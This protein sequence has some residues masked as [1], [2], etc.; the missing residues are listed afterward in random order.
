[1]SSRSPSILMLSEPTPPR[2]GGGAGKYAWQLARQLQ[3]LGNTITLVTIDP[4]ADGIEERDGVQLLRV[5]CRDYGWSRQT[6]AE[7]MRRL[8]PLLR[9]QHAQRRFGLVHDVGGFLYFEVFRQFILETRIPGITHL[10]LL[11]GPYLAEAQI[12]RWGVEYFHSLQELQCG[13]SE[14]V[15]TTSRAESALYRGLFRPPR[16]DDLMIPNG[17]E[18]QELDE[19]RCK[20]WRK[21]LRRDS[22]LLLFVGGRVTDHVKGVQ[23]AIELCRALNARG[24]PARLVATDLRPTRWNQDHEELTYLGRLEDRDLAAVLSCVDVVLCPSHYEAFGLLAVEALSLGVPVV[25]SETGGHLDVVHGDTLGTV[26]DDDHWTDPDDRLL[27]F[28]KRARTVQRRPRADC[29]YTVDRAALSIGRLYR[30]VVG[31]PA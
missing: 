5:F 7:R 8:L 15:I 14:Y 20:T 11:M 22:S 4:Q 10:L 30:E 26:I 29:R 18:N 16:P 13:V 21:R 19:A 17:I 12:P 23:R 2:H 28:L 9:E 24:M 3:K 27:S 6:H 1:M 31:V 25:A